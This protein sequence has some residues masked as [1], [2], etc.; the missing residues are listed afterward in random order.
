MQSSSFLVNVQ[1]MWCSLLCFPWKSNSVGVG[2][3]LDNEFLF[4]RVE[5]IT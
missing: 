1:G 5:R 4:H 2:N 3:N